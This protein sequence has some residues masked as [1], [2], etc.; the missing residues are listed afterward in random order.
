MTE[1]NEKQKK[2]Y[3]RWTEI[4]KKKLFYI[5]LHG[6]V[7][8]GIPVGVLFFFTESHFDKENMDISTFVTSLTLFGIGGLF[9]GLS[10][11]KRNDDIYVQLNDDN[12][13]EDGIR[14]LENGNVWNYE[15]LIIAKEDDNKT[16]IVKN[17]LFWLE[18][19]NALSQ[20]IEEC[21]NI[22]M[23]DFERL[24]MNPGFDMFSRHYNVIAQVY[25][26]SDRVNPLMEISIFEKNKN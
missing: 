24:K 13:I 26:N 10:Q 19:S 17:K 18:D 12:K 7:F 23:K 11:Y 25:N 8:W 2:F 4:R 15:N 6:T 20:N 3:N 14:M 22:V 9:F 1:L 21:M 16:L 5:F